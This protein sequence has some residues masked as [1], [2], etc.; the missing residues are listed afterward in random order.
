MQREL[1]Q[2]VVEA[3]LG[4]D[5][6]HRLRQRERWLEQPVGHGLGHGVLDADPVSEHH[7]ALEHRVDVDEHVATG[8]KL[9]AHVD[10]RRVDER[11]PG[12]HQLA[13]AQPTVL[14]FDLRKLQLVV[15]SQDFGDGR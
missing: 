2:Q 7:L 13:G 9:A 8:L 15:D 1:G 3:A 5:Q 6:P 4:A 11:D 10:P 12:E 14:G